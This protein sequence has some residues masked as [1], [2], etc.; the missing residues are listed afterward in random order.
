MI[1]PYGAPDRAE[2]VEYHAGLVPAARLELPWPCAISL[3]DCKYT[4]QIKAE[5]DSLVT[6]SMQSHPLMQE[7][8]APEKV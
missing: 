3:K 5:P 1:I 6:K 2:T 7:A 4:Y 8:V